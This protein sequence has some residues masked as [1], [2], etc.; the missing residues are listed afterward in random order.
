[1]KSWDLNEMFKI[2]IA[3]SIKYDSWN[4][5]WQHL[6]INYVNRYMLF[7]HVS[8]CTL[9]FYRP[10]IITNTSSRNVN[11]CDYKM[12]VLISLE[13]LLMSYSPYGFY[14]RFTFLG[15]VD[16]VNKQIEINILSAVLI[17]ILKALGKRRAGGTV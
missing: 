10:T 13:H 6:P 17:T 14:F 12:L 5:K 1:M 11:T 3:M 8:L 4:Y 9:R 16:E 2:V 15:N 7:V